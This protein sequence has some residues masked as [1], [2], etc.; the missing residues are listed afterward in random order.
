MSNN[1]LQKSGGGRIKFF[2]T[3]R[4]FTMILV[5]LQH[6]SI[7]SFGINGYE[8][9]LNTALISFRMPLFFFVSGFFAYRAIAVSYTHLTLPTNCT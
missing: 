4:G 3:L 9:V 8:T 6:V 1:N 7:F 2:D 5:V